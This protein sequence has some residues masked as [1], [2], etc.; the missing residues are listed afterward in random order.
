MDG[1]AAQ[2]YIQEVN[3]NETHRHQRKGHERAF[4]SIVDLPSTFSIPHFA[5]LIHPSPLSHRST[6]PASSS[7]SFFPT[8]P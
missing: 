5:F 7:A 8:L 3:K 4:S 6:F 2:S 1:H